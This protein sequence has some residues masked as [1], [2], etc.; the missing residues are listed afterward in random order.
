MIGFNERKDIMKTD[1]HHKHHVHHGRRARRVRRMIY[2]IVL[3]AM[4]GYIIV[5]L[6]QPRPA[7][8]TPTEV[9]SSQPCFGFTDENGRHYIADR[10][11]YF[12]RGEDSC[13][14]FRT[15]P[16]HNYWQYCSFNHYEI[17]R[18]AVDYYDVGTQLPRGLWP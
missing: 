10:F 13:I 4:V 11:H 5:L 14:E 18:F 9:C 12:K 1:K 6:T 8:P 3:L 2:G 17:D 7:G 15:F 16:N